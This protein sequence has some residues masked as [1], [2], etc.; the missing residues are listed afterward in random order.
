MNFPEIEFTQEQAL[1]LEQ[2]RKMDYYAVD[3]YHLPIGLMMENAGLHLARLI[4][5]VAQPGSIIKIGVGN[6]NNGGGGLVAARRLSAWGFRVFLDFFTEIT[7]PLPLM[8]LERALKFGAK[9]EPV[10]NP[11]VWIDAYL[12]FSQKLPLAPEL[13]KRVEEAN[14]S[15]AIR[16]SLDIPTG[17]LG[18]L[19]PSAF[20]ASKVLTLAAPKKILLNLS[21]DTEVYLADLGIPAEVYKLFGINPPPFHKNGIIYLKKYNNG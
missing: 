3:N 17:F 6:G 9:K 21:A 5:T 20:N 10:E 1:E 13:L 16:I 12:G 14:K 4:S 8:Q 15:A 18:E 19:N 7:K 2:F 11:D